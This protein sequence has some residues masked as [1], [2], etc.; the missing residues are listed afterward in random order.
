[1]NTAP[2]W[3]IGPS[4]EITVSP[5]P[6]EELKALRK[7]VRLIFDRYDD[8]VN[9]ALCGD[10]A[11]VRRDAVEDVIA[12]AIQREASRKCI[13]PLCTCPPDNCLPMDP[14]HKP[15]CTASETCECLE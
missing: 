12:L 6:K 5:L 11:K 13:A 9:D 7:E 3:C 4:G 10:K 15:T 1:M 8:W 14:R 2:K